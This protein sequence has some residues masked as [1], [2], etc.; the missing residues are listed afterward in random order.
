M[1]WCGGGEI[2][3]R[4]WIFSTRQYRRNFFPGNCPPSP[5]LAPCA[6]LIS[7][8]FEDIKNEVVT[9]NRP[10]ATCLMADDATSPF[11]KPLKYGNDLSNVR[12]GV[13]DRDK[14]L[15]IF[16][17]F[18]RVGLTTDSVHGDCN[19]FVALLR[20]GAQTCH[21]CKIEKRCPP[22]FN[23]GDIDRLTVGFNVR[24]SLKQVAG[25]VAVFSYNL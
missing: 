1:S 3:A 14:S 21:R 11:F 2:N 9:P 5:G 25:R 4:P 7:C 6:T 19:R 15:R 17:T 23:L 10:E 12:L 8:W 20:N 16:T 18:A 24:R 22:Q 13:R